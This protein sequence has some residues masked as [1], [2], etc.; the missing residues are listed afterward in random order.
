MSRTAP[1]EPAALSAKYV[2]DDACSL[3][4]HDVLSCLGTSANGLSGAEAAARFAEIGPNELPEGEKHTVFQMIVAQFKDFLI[5]LLI[6]AALISGPGFMLL[7]EHPEWADVIAILVIVVLNAT[8]GVFQEYRAER[9]MEAL[10]EM[11]GTVASVRRDGRVFE[12]PARELTV[13]DIVLLDAGRVVPADLRLI[14]AAS[15]KI[16]E[17]ALTGESLPVEKQV[18]PIEETAAP[19]GD[20]WSMAYKGTQVVYGRGVGVVT[21]VGLNTELGKI[22][23]LL[24]TKTDQTTPL[25]KRLASFGRTLGIVAI[26][27]TTIVFA[28]GMLRGEDVMTMFMTAVSLAVAAV[29]EALPAIT[30]IALAF[31]ASR[32]V[33][34]SVLV[35][36][37]PAV[38]TLGSVTYICTDKTG[39]L[40]VNKMTVEAVAD[41]ATTRGALQRNGS[42]ADGWHWLAHAFALS[43]DVSGTGDDLIG[44]PTEVA[45]YVAADRAGFTRASLLS[46]IHISEPTR[47]Y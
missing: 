7:G 34:A 16:A 30:T 35:R 1:L 43:N 13:G 33:K 38:E 27:L 45:F 44:D 9:A 24:G 12:I 22:A 23:G 36:K 21:A 11:A 6:A 3:E 14:D 15:L 4:S 20:R 18:R 10:R 31:G 2:V 25:Q 17:A 8:I 26:G 47:P 29:P 39:T 41:G 32:L 40:T 46:L 5:L 37:L 28:I 19:L 42:A